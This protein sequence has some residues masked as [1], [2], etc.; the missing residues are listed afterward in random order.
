MNISGKRFHPGKMLP[1]GL[2]RLNL[3]RHIQRVNM[4]L[5]IS[6]DLTKAYETGGVDAVVAASQQ[7]CK[8]LLV[9]V[10]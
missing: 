1:F 5:P 8:K 7:Y 6:S 10:R 3:F 2:Y 4:P 9:E